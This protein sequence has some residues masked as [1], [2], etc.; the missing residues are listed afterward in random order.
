MANKD[1]YTQKQIIEALRVSGGAIT[2]AAKI[3]GCSPQTIYNY[4][5][6]YPRVKEALEEPRELMVDVAESQLKQALQRGERWAVQLVLQ[7]LGGKRGYS[8]RREIGTIDGQP[9]PIRVIFDDTVK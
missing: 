4:A 7:T 5:A 3:V 6:K 8:E 1:Q 2:R 9:L